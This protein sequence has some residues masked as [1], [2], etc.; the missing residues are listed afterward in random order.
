VAAVDGGRSGQD[1]HVSFDIFLQGFE[2][3]GRAPGMPEKANQVLQP[4]LQVSP[5]G[6]TRVITDDGDAEV[7]GVGTDGLTF[8]HA[9]GRQVWKVMYEVARAGNWA[10]I[11]VGCPPCVPTPTMVA[12]LPDELRADA[13]VVSSGDEVLAAVL[14]S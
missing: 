1:V 8:T 13:L 11:P 2:N 6:F 3:G 14:R 7:Y 12:H 5:E 9:S 4:Y 10:I